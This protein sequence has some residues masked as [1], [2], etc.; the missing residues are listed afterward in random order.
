MKTDHY[1]LRLFLVMLLFGV[2]G[3]R[4][5]ITTTSQPPE[6]PNIIPPSPTVANLMQFEEVPVDNYTGQ[7]DISVPLVSKSLG[8]GLNLNLALRYNTQSIKIDSRSGWTG[9]G[10]SLEAG[11]VV[12]R[13]VRDVADEKMK[14]IGS[15][16]NQTGIY[17]LDSFWSYPQTAVTEADYITRNRFAWNTNGTHLDKYDSQMDLYQFS[18]L[19]LSGRFIIVKEGPVLVPKLL[20]TD[21]KL[22][23]GLDYDPV[24][25]KIN[26]FT[27][28]DGMGNQYLFTQR[29]L[30]EST[31]STVSYKQY[32]E[33]V[34][35]SSVHPKTKEVT[36]WHLT[37]IFS[38]TGVLLATFNYVGDDEPE[39]FASE[40][41]ESYD[42]PENVTT[43]RLLYRGTMYYIYGI[44][45][46]NKEQ[47]KPLSVHTY[48][49]VTVGTKK[50]G[51]ISFSDGT[52][53]DFTS[54]GAGTHPETGGVYLT[55][56]KY[57][58]GLAI[59]DYSFTYETELSN[60]RLWLMKVSENGLDYN[61]DYFEK[62]RLT[63]FSGASDAWGYEVS[64]FPGLTV[65][66]NNFYDPTAYKRGLL[67]SIS[68]PTGGRK[69]FHFEPHTYSWQGNLLIESF[70]D[71]PLNKNQ[72]SVSS[73]FSAA[74]TVITLLG[75]GTPIVTLS[76]KQDVYATVNLHSG[77][78]S[79]YM[80]SF[81]RM[82]PDGTHQPRIYAN[83]SLEEVDT[84]FVTLEAGSYYYTLT[85]GF[86]LPE[87]L[88][89]WD[90]LE[91]EVQEPDT[92]NPAIDAHINL[93][94][95]T[96]KTG[97]NYKRYFA[98]GGVRIK[99]VLFMEDPSASVPVRSEQYHYDEGDGD[100]IPSG[101][102]QPSFYKTSHSS[103]AI[104]GR[105]DQLV[106]K[107]VFSEPRFLFT[108][109]ENF[110]ECLRKLNVSYEI[111]LKGVAA[112]LSRGNYV[113][114]K[115]V[116][117]SQQGNGY[118]DFTYNSPRDFPSF[119]NGWF[120]YPFT[121]AQNVDYR[122]GLMTN[123]KVFDDNATL[124]SE[125]VNQYTFKE[126]LVA[127]DYTLS[128]VPC[129][130]KP[131]FENYEHYIATPIQPDFNILCVGSPSYKDCFNNDYGS[132]GSP[133]FVGPYL[134]NGTAINSEWAKL[135]STEKTEYFDDGN[136]TDMVYTKVSYVYNTINYQ[137]SEQQTT[138]TK[139]GVPLNFKTS[140][141][142]PADG[143]D[144]SL[145]TSN[146]DPALDENACIANMVSL[147][148][149]NAPLITTSYRDGAVIQRVVN[150]Y[151]SNGLLK[152]VEV[153]KGTGNPEDRIIYGS[154]DDYGHVQE[155]SRPGGAPIAYLWTGNLPVA[156]VENMTFANLTA[157]TS[158]LMFSESQRGDPAFANTM[159]TTLNYAPGGLVAS[160][161][162]QNGKSTL[163][164]YD[165]SERLTGIVDDQGMLISSNDY[166]YASQGGADPRNWIKTDL[167]QEGVAYGSS[168]SNLK[169][170]T[171]SFFDGLGRPEQHIAYKQ[172][173]GGGDVITPVGYDLLGRESKKWLPYVRG[174]A[175][176]SFDATENAQQTFYQA[177]ESVTGNPHFDQTAYAYSETVFDGSP[178]N[179]V[180]EQSA[181][182]A[183]WKRGSG[184][185]VKMEYL[186]NGGNEVKLFQCVSALSSD[187]NVNDRYEA[188]VSSPGNYAGGELYKTVTTDENGQTTSEFKNPEGQVVLK[189]N[190]N[191]S[192]E[193]DTY[194][195][196]DQYGNLSFVLPPLAEGSVT[197]AV[198]DGLCYQYRYDKRNRL[199]EKKLPGKQWE[200]IVYDKLDRVTATGPA[201]AS[202]PLA[203]A[204]NNVGWL[205]TKYDLF[206]RVV[207]TGW[208]A[209]TVSSAERK[210]MQ[211]TN[212]GA[213][214]IN[215]TRVVSRTID[216]K[217][218]YYTNDVTPAVVKLLTVNYYDN[219]SFPN[220]APIPSNG[221]VEDQT[222]RTASQVKGLLTGQFLKIYGAENQMKGNYP[223]Y[224]Y[225][226]QGRQ[227]QKY[228]TFYISGGYRTFNTK[229]DF[230]GKVLYNYTLH[231]RAT[232][233]TPV[234][235]WDY[236]SYT[237]E[238]RVKAVTQKIGSSGTVQL[239]AYH[240]YDHLGQLIGKKVGGTDLTG[241]NAFQ[242]VNY[243][244]NIRGWMTGI[245][246]ADD[247]TIGSDPKDLFAMG[248]TYNGGS[249]PLYNGNIARIDWQTGSDDTPRRYDYVY[250]NLNRLLDATYSK[251]LE[252]VARD[253]YG[254]HIAGY[255][256]N[257][258]ITGL[259]RNGGIN[260]T[261]VFTPAIDDL[262]YVYSS[263]NPN[264]LLSVS[265]GPWGSSIAG[266]KDGNTSGNDYSYDDNGNMIA[267]ANKNISGITYNQMNLP[268]KVSFG[269]GDK[270]EYFYDSQG[271]KVLKIVTQGS[272]V[273]TTDYIEGGVQ[274]TNGV[275]DFMQT[276]EGY[277]KN[278]VVGGNNNFN[279][280]FNYT[281]HVGNVRLS[282]A[283]DP[284]TNVLSI[285][286]EN[287][288]YPFG[289][290]HDYN[291][292]TSEFM[293]DSSNAVVLQGTSS[294][295]YAYQYNGKEYQGEMGLNWNDY[296]AR[297]YDASIGRWMNMDPLAE[298]YRK[299]SPYNYCLDNPIIFIDPDGM[300]VD[301]YFYD[302]NGTLVKHV[303]D[304]RPD[305]KFLIISG[306]TSNEDEVNK[307]IK[308]GE[309]IT[310]PSNEAIKAMDDSY[311]KSKD[312]K[313]E[314]GF[315]A[316]TDG[317]VSKIIEGSK[318]YVNLSEG[319]DDLTAAG[320]TTSYD[321][322][323]H[324]LEKDDKNTT[325]G[326]RPSSSQTTPDGRPGDVESYGR[327]GNNNSLS[328]VLGFKVEEVTTS[329]K[330]GSSTYTNV[331]K[332]IGFYNGTGG[333]GPIIDYNKFKR[334][335]KKINK[336]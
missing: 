60:H 72:E 61:F 25:F 120:A 204:P 240:H 206:N 172:A 76:H 293:K 278:T 284:A 227:V 231:R 87:G 318:D 145:F 309:F 200:F 40:T 262:D 324:T 151:Y 117:V 136:G 312:T 48:T 162:D 295:S 119:P 128:E 238:N 129:E 29:E 289:L 304:E 62:D 308:N 186:T 54:S 266:F 93:F 331:S 77:A 39:E 156:K 133:R 86:L 242:N 221:K 164:K 169:T 249:A 305:E 137:L 203:V 325:G 173:D 272:T 111:T 245:N 250:D 44:N 100:V 230:T 327:N 146:A 18:V 214:T 265:E 14:G 37:Q 131:F 280:V 274:Y 208:N 74:N 176:L 43:N 83:I 296:G 95:T 170:T 174:T 291:A 290:K 248:I 184:H 153:G 94:Y 320:K 79:P 5:Q 263:S 36:A 223:T 122:R 82:N 235:V 197:T 222:I 329:N 110:V 253:Y 161:T 257:G 68:Y 180:T 328:I 267:D 143:Y 154:Y 34:A 31:S 6:L 166:H 234:A 132:C 247:L 281:D 92:T 195:I 314:T 218:V 336:S 50:L 141:V 255:D 59:K 112:E 213:T 323:V 157:A 241:A 91:P 144:T 64:Y 22:E 194:Y 165:A 123:S 102:H 302:L 260:D 158:G 254:E 134:L 261:G 126:T 259:L 193:L 9:T 42:L 148:M 90:G 252:N 27:I 277:V 3:M 135:T 332:M 298:Q 45:T 175:S 306:K 32:F 73:H 19:G 150:K 181:P 104:D 243:K 282:Y 58:D 232:G 139:G 191:G 17:H 163:F 179:R 237:P 246:D 192:E 65:H 85:Y 99:E 326:A 190:H 319:Y 292:T 10:W 98:G 84:G 130:W 288:Y 108:C 220:V 299:W 69:V 142:Y 333:V 275:L 75:S 52:S 41:D 55:G 286:G 12:S 198:L 80:L 109:S 13:T 23:I 212:N 118:S 239:M 187:P 330:F 287:N 2:V 46:Y 233:A 51:H 201:L 217:T 229:Y 67:S 315:V 285:L 56:L 224:F 307:S 35:P 140:Y 244:Y 171:K 49:H 301:S 138:I 264:Q 70:D 15:E 97:E 125:T 26:S 167:Y 63:A 256:K 33:P 211:G 271:T 322:H 182:G 168:P 155:V 185:T 178:L 283:K 103:G 28:T 236:F 316:A 202:S 303:D 268:H 311:D 105:A 24:T 53:I 276:P 205:I 101:I 273:T 38:S 47:F 189:R 335:V 147:H 219:Y 106:K 209:G 20:S 215:E 321:A 279:Y 317:S 30:T 251:P 127:K 210:T 78:L 81:Y 71:E 1:I 88:T 11:G 269:N 177:D 89:E 226:S 228:T 16:N 300:G 124:L 57:N 66:G 160:I 294:K 8:F 183:D 258:N 116:R 7:P 270:I 115:H 159:V 96:L 207:Y 216:G 114:Y 4:G 113:G 152:E 313:N 199:I 121:P 188:T 196:Y 334:T 149:L 297:N 21:Q 225:D 107:Y 310:V